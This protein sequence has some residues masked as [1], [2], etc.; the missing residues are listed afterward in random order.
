MV[1]ERIFLD[2]TLRSNKYCYNTSLIKPTLY[3]SEILLT[4]L[5]YSIC[6]IYNLYRYFNFSYL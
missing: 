4:Y 6:I 5:L 3:Y 2:I 1:V